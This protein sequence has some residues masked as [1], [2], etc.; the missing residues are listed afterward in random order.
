MLDSFKH[1]ES[2]ENKQSACVHTYTNNKEWSR[3]GAG[4]EQ[5]TIQCWGVS[6]SP[7]RHIAH[8]RRAYGRRAPQAREVGVHGERQ[9]T[10]LVLPRLRFQGRVPFEGSV[11]WQVEE[12]A[13]YEVF[14]S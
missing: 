11:Q 5:A 2:K 1:K 9:F 8:K 6:R 12:T 14:R 7:Q 13:G 4:A 10:M 3:R